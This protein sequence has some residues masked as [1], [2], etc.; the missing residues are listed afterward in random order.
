MI[1]YRL[2]AL[3]GYSLGFFTLFTFNFRAN[4]A[5]DILTLYLESIVDV[6]FIRFKI[7]LLQ[8]KITVCCYLTIS[9]DL[10]SLKKCNRERNKF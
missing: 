4:S 6:S 10:S 2:R 8:E 3:G 9:I 5:S 1:G 7:N